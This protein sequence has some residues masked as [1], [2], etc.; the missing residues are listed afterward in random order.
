MSKHAKLLIV[1]EDP[2]PPDLQHLHERAVEVVSRADT[3][4]GDF[5]YVV[6]LFGACAIYCWRCGRIPLQEKRLHSI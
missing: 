4:I 6:F 5:D 2:V 3:L 1:A